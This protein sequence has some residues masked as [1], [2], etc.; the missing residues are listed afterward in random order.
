MG[1]FE[2]REQKEN[3]LEKEKQEKEKAL[4]QEMHENELEKQENELYESR[5][6]IKDNYVT[7]VIYGSTYENL[8][9]NVNKYYAQLAV[10]NVKF[11]IIKINT[12][13]YALGEYS[14]SREG[15]L[16]QHIEK[17]STKAVYQF[18]ATITIKIK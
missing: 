1:L 2:S 12:D 14:R 17:T 7:E 4:E 6:T 18:I 3:R 8:I 11:D 15:L 5:Y 13:S 10:R 16:F 9:I